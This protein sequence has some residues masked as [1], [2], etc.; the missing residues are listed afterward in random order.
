MFSLY[1]CVH[2]LFALKNYYF[3]VFK[4]N[5]QKRLKRTKKIKF[6]LKKKLNTVNSEINA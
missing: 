4:E 2:F 6:C 1:M 3:I 5:P